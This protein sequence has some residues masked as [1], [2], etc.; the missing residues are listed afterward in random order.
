LFWAICE[1]MASDTTGYINRG[2]I[3]GLSVSFGIEAE[4][5]QKIIDYCIEIK[6]FSQCEHGN[7]FNQRILDHK[8]IRHFL[9]KNGTLGNEKRWGKR[10]GNRG[11]I[12]TRI[13]RIGE[14][15]IGEERYIIPPT[16]EMVKKYCDER[17]NE[18]DPQRFIDSY[19]AKGWMIGKNKMKDWQAS[20]R[21]W[22][23]SNSPKPRQKWIPQ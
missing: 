6:L 12:A 5:L 3:G 11:A 4:K 18:I 23:K 15:R 2:A 21:T 13:A 1:T 8:K 9:S 19:T 7:Y 16:L 22:E 20:V 14:D 10:A 17:K